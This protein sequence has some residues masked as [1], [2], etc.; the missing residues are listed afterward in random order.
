MQRS[1]EMKKFRLLVLMIIMGFTV[2]V[3]YA[4]SGLFAGGEIGLGIAF[5]EYGYDF[6][7]NGYGLVRSLGAVKSLLAFP[8][9]GYVGYGI[10]SKFAVTGGLMLSF[11]Q[12]YIF[13]ETEFSTSILDIPIM[14]RYAFF[15]ESFIFGIQGGLYMG[16]P[17]GAKLSSNGYSGNI[18]NDGVLFGGTGGFFGGYPVG[19]G[20]VMGEIRFHKDFNAVK[21]KSIGEAFWRTN[22]LIMVGY[23][24]SF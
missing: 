6:D 22:L 10:T 17:I 24:Y 12:G 11:N 1:F 13:N 18:D 23:E 16:I 5:N 20:R 9:A 2:P 4:Q 21:E 19:P 3:V 7:S 14:L 15:N 8:I